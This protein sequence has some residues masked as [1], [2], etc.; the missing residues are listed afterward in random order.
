MVSSGGGKG[1]ERAQNHFRDSVAFCKVKLMDTEKVA[2][3]RFAG[4][5]FDEKGNVISEDL[6]KNL[7]SY[8]DAFDKWIKSNKK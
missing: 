6:K 4:K 5:L 7:S 2:V 1:G 3:N 8:L